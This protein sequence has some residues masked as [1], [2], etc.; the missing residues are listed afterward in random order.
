[1]SRKVGIL[2]YLTNKSVE[3]ICTYLYGGSN[4]DSCAAL[5]FS[6]YFIDIERRTECGHEQ[7]IAPA[8]IS[9][10][11]QTCYEKGYLGASK[12]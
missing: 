11:K 3:T 2:L 1:M 7:N 5:N 10:S 8:E 12:P 4:C 6:I 9:V